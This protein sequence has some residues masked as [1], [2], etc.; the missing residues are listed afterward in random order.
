MARLLSFLT[1]FLLA[2][3]V[4]GLNASGGDA[5]IVGESAAPPGRYEY[6]ADLQISAPGSASFICGGTL[7]RSDIVLTAAQCF[8]EGATIS[9]RINASAQNGGI[10]RSVLKMVPHPDYQV[11]KIGNDIMVLKL[12][13]PVSSVQPVAYNK[14]SKF[15]SNNQVLTVF[16]FGA[17]NE[18][19]S[20]PSEKLR[21]VNV[22][23]GDFGECNMQYAF[24]LDSNRHVC[25]IGPPEGG[26]DSCEGDAGAPLIIKGS[27]SALDV[28]VGL[29]SFGFGC[30]R[31]GSFSGNTNTAGYSDWISKQIC[32][33]ST[34]KLDDCPV[35]FG[36]FSGSSIVHVLDQVET[37]LEKVKIG[38]QVMVAPGRYES[39]YSFGHYSSDSRGVFLEI[40]TLKSTLQVS[41]DHMVFD[42]HNRAIPASALRV[43][44]EMIDATGTK[45]P[46]VTIKSIVA[47]GVFAPFTPS[48]R[49]VVD[50]TLASSY[51]T[52]E[53]SEFLKIGGV[54][55]SYQWIAHSFEFPHRVMCHYFGSC[56][57]ETYTT[58]GIS[59]WVARP[60]EWGQWVL[61]QQV[62]FR[63]SVLVAFLTML[64]FF[65]FLENWSTLTLCAVFLFSVRKY[66]RVQKAKVA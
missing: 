1:H 5:R 35:G 14:E 31:A 22:F 45:A 33:F 23:A 25:T 20:T 50:N 56:P 24:L 41:S 65:N 64:L 18:F 3:S 54:A 57:K 6:Y 62:I 51:V 2:S 37:T 29:V 4:Q 19:I 8:R 61:K 44:D 11:G 26:S 59:Q 53:D 17:Q 10:Q 16:G 39:V 21:E 58:E 49:I 28:Q 47:L 38:D 15:P 55:F 13:E 60:H 7:I 46:I 36:C 66:V 42:G 12:S 27:N 63:N 43:G 48:G 34:D 32:D 52:F 40:S 9:V 30:G